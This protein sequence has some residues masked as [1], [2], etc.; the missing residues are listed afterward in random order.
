MASKTK[1]KAK[2]KKAHKSKK[3]KINRV[4]L[5]AILTVI[6]VALAGVFAYA[7]INVKKLEQSKDIDFGK[8]VAVGVD[9]SSHNGKIDFNALKN[10]YD[11]VI[12]RVGYRGYANGEIKLDKNAKKNLIAANLA[13]VPAGVYFYS[14]AITPNEAEQEAK[15]VL[16]QIK[17]YNVS[18]PVFFD[19]EYAADKTGKVGRLYE[20]NLSAKDNTQLVNSFCSTIEKAG[21]KSGVYASSSVYKWQLKPNKIIK[22]AYIWVADYNESITYNGSYDLW[23]YTKKGKT[24]AVKSKYVDINYWYD[25][26]VK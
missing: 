25:K 19:F 5:V 14:Q 23:Q 9:I 24:D 6:A 26:G 18:L 11:Y 17:N 2:K 20:A 3:K 7:S 10:Q 22:S 13:G 8:D 15:F 12:I 4:S 21:Y 16:K 1:T